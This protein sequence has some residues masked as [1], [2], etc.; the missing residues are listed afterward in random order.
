MLG[1]GPRG[2]GGGKTHSEWEGVRVP[3]MAAMEGHNALLR[4]ASHVL[5]RRWRPVPA[6][7]GSPLYWGVNLRISAGRVS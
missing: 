2:G 7:W 5:A 1:S 4:L 6:A 3:R